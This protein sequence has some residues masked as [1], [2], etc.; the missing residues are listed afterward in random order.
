M[1]AEKVVKWIGVVNAVLYSVLLL[2]WIRNALWGAKPAALLGVQLYPE[3]QVEEVARYVVGALYTVFKWT[4]IAVVVISGIGAALGLVSE[5]IAYVGIRVPRASL[6]KLLSDTLQ[7]M[8]MKVVV[9]AALAYFGYGSA[10]LAFDAALWG[11]WLGYFT[12]GSSAALGAWLLYRA[13][14]WVIEI[15]GW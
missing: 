2:L 3:L 1:D 11:T 13:F 9:D 6:R 14:R 7:L 4:L 8:L 12:V 10:L 15:G 5:Y